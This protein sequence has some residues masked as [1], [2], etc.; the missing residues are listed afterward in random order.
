MCQNDEKCR[1]CPLVV[2][3]KEAID[4]L[5]VL[6]NNQ[7]TINQSS[8]Q[9]VK[10]SSG[11]ITDHIPDIVAWFVDECLTFQVQFPYVISDYDLELLKEKAQFYKMN[12][13][14]IQSKRAY[15]TKIVGTLEL[16]KKERQ[17][18][19]S[20]AELTKDR[21]D[22]ALADDERKTKE[23]HDFLTGKIDLITDDMIDRR[24]RGNTFLKSYCKSV[25]NV[26]SSEPLLY[27]IA[28]LLDKAGEI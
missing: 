4:R 11:S 14:T 25:E 10:P 9:S 24:L 5:S 12:Q 28:D 27:A 16:K 21:Q 18:D 22:R 1:T 6:V 7:S 13:Q 23:R 20:D 3:L 19:R 8:V 17:K 26:R 2:G 15:L